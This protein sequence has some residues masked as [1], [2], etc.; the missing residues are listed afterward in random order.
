MTHRTRVSVLLAAATLL[1]A[2]CGDDGDN[3]TT[4]DN[5][6]QETEQAADE[7]RDAAQNAWAS[8]RT[9]A[10]RL[11]DQ[12]RTQDAPR[13][14]EQLLDRCRDTLER[15]RQAESERAG[16]V[17]RLCDRIRNTDVTSTDAW[18]DIKREIDQLE[19]TR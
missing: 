18:N 15:L 1:F 19:P 10:E 12:I 16:E 9:D 5:V 3:Q 17:D 4:V 11:V 6:E 2:G 8:V 13:L 14:K 7:A